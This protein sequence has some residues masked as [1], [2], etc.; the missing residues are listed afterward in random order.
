MDA[1]VKERRER[2]RGD[3]GFSLIEMMMAITILGVGLL[4]L[5][6]LFPIAMEKVTRG[7]ME[8]KATF[9]A[10]GKL[11]ELKNVPWD[12]LL[13]SASNDVVDVSFQRTWTIQENV[14]TAGMKTVQV[15]VNWTDEDGPRSVTLST[16]LSNSGI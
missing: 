7:D 1:M 2:G 9:H 12:Q 10:Q 11:E 13:S 14:P 5:G 4:S 3:R 6:G 8:S 16:L 15:V